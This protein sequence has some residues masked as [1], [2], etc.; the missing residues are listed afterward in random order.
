MN[1]LYSVLGTGTPPFDRTGRGSC[2]RCGLASRRSTT[3][4]GADGESGVPLGDVQLGVFVGSKST[5]YSMSAVW[6]QGVPEGMVGVPTSVLMVS[7]SSL[8][9]LLAG[10]I[11]KKPCGETLVLVAVAVVSPTV[12]VVAELTVAPAPLLSVRVP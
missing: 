12:R 8:P 9:P 1:G 3:V 10:P 7:R 5:L 4:N 6:N 11:R 2:G